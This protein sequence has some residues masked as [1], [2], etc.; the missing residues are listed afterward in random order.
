MVVV[1]VPEDL[2]LVVTL[3]VTF[4]TKWMT[5][6]KLV[7]SLGSCETMANASV[8][9]THE[10]R[11]LTHN[12]VSV[13]AGSIGIHTKFVRNLK[14]NKACTNAPNQEQDQPQEQDVTAQC[15]R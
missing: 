13:V 11:T 9:C 8:V 5:E 2:P 6:E 4:T 14:E 3:A 15:R 12:I 7:C 10:T 1:T